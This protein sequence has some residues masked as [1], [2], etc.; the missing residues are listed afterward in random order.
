MS[1]ETAHRDPYIHVRKLNQRLEVKGT[2]ACHLGHHLTS[3]SIS[4]GVF[5]GWKW[6]GERLR[7]VN[8]RFGF[9]PLYYFASPGECAVSPSIPNLLALGAP[10]DLDYAALAV[11]F[12]L[13]FFLAEDTPFLGIR[14]LPSDVEFEWRNESLTVSGRLAFPKPQQLDRSQ[15]LEAYVEVFRQAILR[16]LPSG[17]EFSMLLSGGRDSRH[18]LLELLHNGVR[19]AFCLTL[20]L[21]G[22]RAGSDAM[23]AAELTKALDVPHVILPTT[24][25]D[26]RQEM[27]KNHITN[28]CTDEHGWF[29]PAA[30]YLEGRSKTVFDGIGGDV[31][32]AGLSMTGD[33][34]SLAEQGRSHELAED[35]IG[36]SSMDA[37]ICSEI[38]RHVS[39]EVALARIITELKR[40]EAAA[41]PV[42]SFIFWNRTRREIALSPYRLLR[43]IETVVCPYLDYAVYDL[44]AGL[45]G[46]MFVD[47]S[48]H[49]EAIKLAFPEHRHIG[50]A[51]HHPSVGEDR[52]LRRRFVIDV[53]RYGVRQ[54][55]SLLS[56]WSLL[57]RLMRCLVDEP[58]LES[59][60]W[61]GPAALYLLQLDSWMKRPPAEPSS[62]RCSDNTSKRS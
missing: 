46:R 39:R 5:A 28:L 21:H 35:L 45:P 19:P 43:G 37:L 49:T 8:D 22:R 16:R 42:G 14:A 11:F 57:I 10:R 17:E 40:H 38:K 9:Y 60:R 52:G 30:R 56:K 55:S 50:Y 4:Q 53:A 20:D 25:A 3:E 32:S 59:I 34:L 23:V 24:H 27:E 36:Q 29:L 48:F 7:V 54:K 13:G 6:D 12:H 1:Y 2:P 33:R 62:D 15:A 18:I 58:Y 44:L 47:H 61:L 41:N 31:L 26:L 51:M